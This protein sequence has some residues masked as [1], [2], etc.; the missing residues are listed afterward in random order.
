M[1]NISSIK[2]CFG[3]GV[4]AIVC[5]RNLISIELNETG[6]YE[7]A[8]SNLD[9]CINCGLCVECCSFL[10]DGL[11][12]SNKKIK[13]YGAWSRN[14]LTR[15]KCTSGGVS[16]E[17]GKKAIEEGYKVC[18]VRYNL[19]K[20]I[21]EHYIAE[22][23]DE[24]KESIG[25]KYIQSY[26]VDGLKK[27]N[28]N[29]KYFVTG[30]PCQIDSF[31]RYI[32][33]FRIEDNF[34]LLDFFCHG[35]PSMWLWKKY[36]LD[37]EK[38]Y[39]KFSQ[40]LW[41]NKE[42][43]WNNSYSLKIDCLKSGEKIVYE[44]SFQQNDVFYK[45]FLSDRCLGCACYDNC[46]FKY[47]NSSADIRIG[48][49]WG[50]HYKNNEDGVSSV[51]TFSKK[52]EIWIKKSNLE[53]ESLPLNVATDGQMKNNAC[54]SSDYYRVRQVLSDSNTSISNVYDVI[55]KQEFIKKILGRLKHPRRTLKN[56]I[57]RL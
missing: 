38:K 35:V 6:F 24:L 51:L 29:D 53:L 47:V 41:R 40:V 54:R 21:A 1:A 13:S 52:G 43:G 18:A 23:Y 55:K 57:K 8:I 7:P 20:G 37:I 14:S 5:T 34:L 50:K 39:G 28:R 11:A 42:N 12:S 33:K 16:Y 17:I 44:S 3:C 46:K 2:N 45:F 36:S 56:L 25:S 48:D 49:A 19:E 32:K 26:T 15:K 22:N 30:T 10:N 4:C 31:R 27:I 9:K